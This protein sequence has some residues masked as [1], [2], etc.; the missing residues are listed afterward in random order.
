[1]LPTSE[2]LNSS[3]SPTC[4]YNMVD[5]GPLAAEIG[6][7]VWHTPANFSGFRVLASLLQ[8]RRSMEANQTLHDVW[9]SPG[10]IG[11]E[12]MVGKMCKGD[13]Y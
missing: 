5:F 1:M 8:Q 7:L 9:P 13:R 12:S 3:I 10:L 11:S 2:K 6:W 4:P